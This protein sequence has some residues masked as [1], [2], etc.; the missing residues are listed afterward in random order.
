MKPHLQI[1][2]QNWFC[3][4]DVSVNVYLGLYY[5]FVYMWLSYHD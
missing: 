3:I 1:H 2:P 5:L 4:F